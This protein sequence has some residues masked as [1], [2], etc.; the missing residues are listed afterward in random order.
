MSLT[1]KL[2]EDLIIALKGKKELDISTLRLVFSEINNAKID[3]GLEKDKPLEDEDV[4][5]IISKNAKKNKESIDAYEKAERKELAE[6][7][8]AELAIL[9]KYLPEQMSEDEVGKIVDEVITSFGAKKM[10][11][12]GQVMGQVMGKLKGKADGNLVSKLV[13]EKLS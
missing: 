8:K 3:K 5:A 7:E 11:E 1:K 10:S 13:K 9:E 2:E 4:I 12:M 6:K